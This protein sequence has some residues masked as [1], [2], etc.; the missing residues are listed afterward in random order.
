MS[1]FRM[2]EKSVNLHV[3]LIRKEIVVTSV[4]TAVIGLVLVLHPIM[5]LLGGV[6]LMIPLIVSGY[7]AQIKIFGKS[8]YGEGSEIYHML[9]L[10]PRDMLIGKALAMV[11]WE[12][13]QLAALMIPVCVLYFRSSSFI[14]PEFF[15][16]MTEQLFGPGL[17]PAQ[18]GILAGLSYAGLLIAEFAWCMYMV[19]A[20]NLIHRFTGNLAAKAGDFP[21]IL[22]AGLLLAAVIFGG[23]ML[24]AMLELSGTAMFCFI[25]GKYILLLA[26]GAL[27]YYLCRENLEK[28]YGC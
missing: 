20:Q 1:D 25:I 21:C 15:M 27:L 12:T 2:I 7:K 14:D 3:D 16:K 17:S 22:F 4:F 11:V 19:L 26:T 13:A 8:L 24:V 10:S 23:R 6:F 28:A 18:M 9:P 5:F